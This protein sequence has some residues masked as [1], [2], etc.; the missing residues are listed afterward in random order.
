MKKLFSIVATVALL[1]G[2]TPVNVLGAA[3]YSAELEGAYEYAYGMG[4]T[5]MTS[6]NNADMYGNLTRIALAKMISNYVLELGLQTPDTSK[7]CKFTDVSTPL[8]T[9]Y[10]N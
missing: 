5:T 7:E 4:V 9:Q 8:D 1:A 2:L 10:A 6:I 3:S